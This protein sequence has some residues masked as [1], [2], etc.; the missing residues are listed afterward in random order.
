MGARTLDDRERLD[1]L[2]LSR[3]ENVGAQTFQVLIDR[4]GD[5]A[6]AMEALPDLAARGG[7]RRAIRIYDRDRAEADLER[8]RALGARFVASCEDDYPALL[9]HIA[10]PPPLICVK[11]TAGVVARPMVAIVGSRNASAVGRKFARKLAGELGPAGYTIVSG[12]AR[13]IDTAAHEGSL[14]S[15]TAAVLAGGID[16]IY[17]PENEGLFDAIADAGLLITEHVPGTRP[18]AQNFPRRNR[19]V[20]GMSWGVIVV[21]A[22]LRS[23]SLITAKLALEQ[24]R[25]VFAVP[26]SPLDPRAEGTNKLIKDGAVLVQSVSDVLE[27]LSPLLAPPEQPASSGGGMRMEEPGGPDAPAP[28]EARAA[29]LDLIGSAPVDIDDLIRESGFSASEVLTSLLEL[30]LAGLVQRLPQQKILRIP[31]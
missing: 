30:E 21:E 7:I 9:R 20:S 14:E 18:R 31:D 28:E 29:L 16:N 6:S 5:A 4:Y 1:W 24:N 2:Q 17:P 19:L 13:G 26:G 27:T 11:G 8:T 23:G 12:L 22:A 25:E 10:D 3:T 15:G